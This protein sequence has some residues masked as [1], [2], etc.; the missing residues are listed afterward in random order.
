MEILKDLEL[1]AVD[2]ENNST[3]AVLT[4][5]DVNRSEVRRVN[6]NL[7]TYD[8]ATSRYIDDPEKEKKVGEWC[9]TYF[10]CSFY[11][12]GSRIGVKKDVYAYDNFN[13][14]WEC[15]VIEKFTEEDVGEFFSTTISEIEDDGNAIRIRFPYGDKTY[16]SKMTYATY[17]EAM[18]QW[19]VDPIKKQEVYKKFQTKFQC[20]IEN[21]DKLI[22]HQINVE[23]KKAFNKFAYADIKKFPDKKGK[24]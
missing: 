15:S 19:F 9:Q 22:G 13:S 14:L 11:D 3:K 6:F 12:L 7:Q 1:V 23:V 17:I 5:L 21:K 8:N 2:Y 20:P 18:K 24:K 16:E 10:G 4:F